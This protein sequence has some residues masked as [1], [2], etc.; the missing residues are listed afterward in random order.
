MTKRIVVKLGTSVLTRGTPQLNRPQMVEIAR[1]CA[2]VRE[3]G[4]EVII[5]S[6]GAQAVGREQLN[7]PDLPKTLINKQMLSAVGQGRLMQMWGAFFEIYNIQ[8]GQI[9][10]TRGDFESRNRYLNARETLQALVKHGVIPIINENDSVA[11]DEI[12]VGDNDNLSAFVSIIAEADLLILLTDQEG[13]FTADPRFNP[14]AEL[15]RE[16]E[17]IDAALYEIA[18]DSVTGLGTGGMAT[19]LESA[20]KAT[21]AGIT[22]N[23]AH[24]FLPNV[25]CRLANGEQLGTCF[26]PSKTPMLQRKQWLLDGSRAAGEIIIDAGAVRALREQGRSLLP[27]G[28]S[29]ITGEFHRGHTLDVLDGAGKRIGR[30]MTRYSSSALKTIAGCQSAEISTKLGYS[31]GNAVIHRNDFVLV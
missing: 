16:V 10:L 7:Y 30:G 5:C 18:G 8:T 25:I 24:G 28:I 13:L 15:I 3:L 2:A 19:K 4:H 1:Q 23:I 11:N 20:E 9:L 14:A 22:V 27:A 21:R 6:S 31:Y 12:R 29:A 17:T 26:L